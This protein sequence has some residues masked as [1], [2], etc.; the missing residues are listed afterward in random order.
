MIS[1]CNT[2]PANCANLVNT[3]IN[4]RTKALNASKAGV[5]KQYD[6]LQVANED[7]KGVATGLKNFKHELKNFP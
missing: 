4:N 3:Y 6:A 1:G 5:D 2:D 7:K